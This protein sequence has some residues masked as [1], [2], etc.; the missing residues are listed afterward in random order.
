MINNN[1]NNNTCA[2]IVFFH[3]CGSFDPEFN[4][5]TPFLVGANVPIKFVVAGE[6][7]VVVVEVWH[8]QV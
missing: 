8:V 3:M 4:F 5:T 2:C 1:N 6:F 7:V